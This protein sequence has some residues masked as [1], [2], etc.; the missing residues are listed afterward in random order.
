M[1]CYILNVV[2]LYYVTRCVVTIHTVLCSYVMLLTVYCVR[3]LCYTLG[4]VTY[5]MLYTMYKYTYVK[6][7][8]MMCT[9]AT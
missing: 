4:N 3:M 9:Y 5:F 2:Y 7:Y 6:L 1:L 8:T